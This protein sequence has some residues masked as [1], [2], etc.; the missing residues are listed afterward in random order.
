MA[1][2]P[3]SKYFQSKP[4]SSGIKAKASSSISIEKKKRTR[5]SV[6]EKLQLLKKYEAG[7]SVKSLCEEYGVKKQTVS[8]IKK[9]KERLK[10]WSATS[11]NLGRTSMKGSK[12]ADLDTAVYKWYVQQ[13]AVDVMV[14]GVDIMAAAEKLAQHMGIACQAS[15][16]WLWRFRNRHGIRNITPHGEAGSADTN[17][18]EPFRAKLDWLIKDEKWQLN[19]LYNGDETALFWRSLPR[20]TQAFRHEDK[21]PGRKISKEK[22]SALLGANA[23][24]THRLTPCIVGKSAKPRALKDL[25]H[26]LPVVYYNTKNAW[27]NGAIFEDW[28]F[29]HFVPEVRNYQEKVLGIPPNE[30]RA[31]LLL[32]NAP[33]HP[34]ED[35]LKTDDGKI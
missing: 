19:Q 26:E 34:C 16:G 10:Q 27:F 17:A 25:M 4:S 12:Q 20:N 7:V 11:N 23:T 5:L 13:R 18:V 6:A 2:T 14:R 30:V 28:F 1:P 32:D 24:G 33:A 21:T 9:D 15:A 35:R 8:D 31:L 29:K 3:I 22:L